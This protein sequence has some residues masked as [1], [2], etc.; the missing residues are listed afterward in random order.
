MTANLSHQIKEILALGRKEA[1]RLQ[2][3]QVYAE[4][5]VLGILQH[6][7]CL[8]FQI[9]QHLDAPITALRDILEEAVQGKKAQQLALGMVAADQV[10]LSEEVENLLKLIHSNARFFNITT[11]GT[12]HLL[13]AIL[14]GS[15][16][17]SDLLERFG[18]THQG[19][20]ELVMEQLHQWAAESQ[21]VGKGSE[22]RPSSSA[23]DQASTK[24]PVLDGVGRDLS[25][26]AE[27]GKLDPI[28]GR[29][30]EI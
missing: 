10:P 9:I 15:P 5:L 3:L 23:A 19:V 11:I 30:Q 18:I 12:G 26:L 28:I 7:R 2:S 20:E 17:T 14:E 8:A 1:L 24:T 22:V 13:L 29:E 25:K 6:R 27:E 16:R 4:H 21:R